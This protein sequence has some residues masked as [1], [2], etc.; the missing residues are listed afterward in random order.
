MELPSCAHLASELG[1]LPWV[2]SEKPT[3]LTS[4][5]GGL[6]WSGGQSRVEGGRRRH[7]Q[8]SLGTS[9]ECTDHKKIYPDRAILGG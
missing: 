5:R 2:F 3:D 9:P 6:G 8:Q 7:P 4:R 1:R